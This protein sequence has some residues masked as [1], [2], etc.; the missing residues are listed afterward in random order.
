MT[1]DQT[2]CVIGKK[3]RSIGLCE[4]TEAT[5]NIFSIIE[6]EQVFINSS[7][8]A[9]YVA[10]HDEVATLNIIERWHDMGKR[11]VLPRVVGSQMDFVEYT[12]GSL[13]KGAFGI[14]EPTSNSVVAPS[15]IEL[16]ILPGVA[17]CSDGRRLGRGGGYYD[18]YLSQ[19]DFRGYTIGVG[20]AHQLLEDI[21]CEEHDISLS[22][23]IT[24]SK[25]D[26]P[27]LSEV[28]VRVIDSAS[29]AANTLGCGVER[30]I[31][32][33]LT[34]VLSRFSI[35]IYKMPSSIENMIIETW[36][37][38]CKRIAT[39]RNFI[40][41]DQ[42]GERL[43]LATSQWC[44]IDIKA[45]RPVDLTTP[46]IDYTRYI[47]PRNID[48]ERPRK[49]PQLDSFDGEVSTSYHTANRLDIDINNHVNTMRYI[50]MMLSMV[51]KKEYSNLRVDIHFANESLL[52]DMLTINSK[53]QLQPESRQLLFEIIRPNGTPSVRALF[54]YRS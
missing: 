54:N 13:Q 2:R 38:D 32:M 40:I 20:Y 6:L 3:S 36:I 43:A 8:I 39:T 35:D 51:E 11:V 9:L 25:N 31:S 41:T 23:V 14:L 49:I 50:E 30:L 28:I 26:T 16:M 5:Y 21:P 44:M 19:S 27:Q 46:D 29:S 45:R 48:I 12:S 47:Q 1:K 34:W 7:C 52:G 4:R 15:E 10:L 18:R 37:E 22:R 53:E 24:A 42:N 17:F 33:G